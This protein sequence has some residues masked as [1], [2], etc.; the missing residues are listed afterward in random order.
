MIADGDLIALFN[1]PTK[2]MKAEKLLRKAGLA[3]RLI[4]APRQVAEGCALALRFAA[5]EKT[6]I[7]KELA[8]SNLTPRRLYGKQ[9]GLLSALELTNE[10]G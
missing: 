2:V 8:V 5:S 9:Q 10:D 7:F 1:S 4:P 3:C 6:V